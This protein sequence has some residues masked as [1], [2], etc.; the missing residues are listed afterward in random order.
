MRRKMITLLLA[1]ALCAGL[2]SCAGSDA[3]RTVS[4]E[5]VTEEESDEQADEELQKAIDLGLVPENLQRNYGKQI[6]YM[7]FC[8]VLDNVTA[9]LR[10]EA[11]ESW[12]EISADYRDQDQPM[13]R[14]EGAVVMLYAAENSGLDSAGYQYRLSMDELASDDTDYFGNTPWD[15][16]LLPDIHETYYNK[17]YE[18]KEGESWRNGQEYW[19]YSRH[20]VEFTSYES[21]KTYFDYNE[22]YTMDMEA[23]F[24]RSDAI[25]AVLRFYETAEYFCYEPIEKTVV[26]AQEPWYLPI[27]EVG[28]YNKEII[29]DEILK[30]CTLGEI[31]ADNLPYWTG[32]HLENKAFLWTPDDGSWDDATPG[33]RYFTEDQIRFQ[34]EQGFNYIRVLYSFSFLSNPDDVY[35]INMAELEQ[36]DEVLSWCMKYNMHMLLSITGLPGQNGT[37]REKEDTAWNDTLFR[38]PEMREV[39]TDYWMM[40]AKRYADIPT[41][42]LSYEMEAESF[43]STEDGGPD[44]QLYCDTL[45]PIA[46][47]I[48]ERSPGRIVIANDNCKEP[49]EQL[50]E[51]GCC[52][53]LH[54]YVYTLAN[55]YFGEPQGFEDVDYSWPM[56][57]IPRYFHGPYNGALVLQSESA[58]CEGTLKV[59]TNDFT[60]EMPEVL[61]DGTAVS[62]DRGANAKGTTCLTGRIPDGTK[63]IS[64]A[65]V[66]EEPH[67]ELFLIELEQEG[68]NRVQLPVTHI[69]YPGEE[70]F[71]TLLVADDGTVDGPLLTGEYI[72]DTYVKKFVE[73]AERNNVTFIDTEI[74]TDTTVLSV[75][76]YLTYHTMWLDMMKDHNISWSFNCERNFFAPITNMWYNGKNN[77]IPFENFSQ[78][79][80]SPYWVNDDVLELLKSYQ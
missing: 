35:S 76:E 4:E 5:A 41:G 10:P 58:F 39:F 34:A 79:E 20:F 37:S 51:M 63:E 27:D 3:D 28:T 19:N 29:T 62:V 50:A 46:Y 48:W 12:K 64:F 57:Y 67:V 49:P 9:L 66:G 15:F 54:T 53:S 65:S 60:D 45:A 23:P 75:E 78:W 40:I 18:N 52:L 1:M 59:Y 14:M 31:T 13:T 32:M 55:Y 33:M 11:L 77:P 25:R 26:Q 7:E 6:T 44:M 74:G 38:D 16:P 73:C 72:Y 8:Q 70:V 42:A 43:C 61:C 69:D 47:G 56:V 2:V 24:I 36:L 21:G 68:R 30:G 71:P 80:D 17:V 22:N